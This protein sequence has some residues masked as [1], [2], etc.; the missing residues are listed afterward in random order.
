MVAVISCMAPAVIFIL[1]AALLSL[2][3]ERGAM[4]ISGF[5][6]MPKEK[7]NIYDKLKLVK[8]MRNALLLWAVIFVIGS[9][10]SFFINESIAIFTYALWL[11]LFLRTV[12]LDTDKAFEK[13]KINQK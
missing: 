4:L 6:T 11:F 1:F 8:D 12:H 7:R 5:N 13:Y 9:L 3:R 10:L 2:L